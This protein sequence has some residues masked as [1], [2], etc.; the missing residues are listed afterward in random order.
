MAIYS[1]NHDSFGKTT[2]HA[3]AAGENAAY[4]AREKE[5]NLSRDYGR[6]SEAAL[7]AAYNA[8]EEATYAVRSHVIPASPNEAEAWFR[9]QEK[10]ERKNA[11]MS[12]RFIGA[13]PREL[14]PDQCIEAVEKFCREVTQ[15]RVPW[16]FALHLELDKRDEPDWNPHAHI[17]IRD[18][19]IET[20]RRVLF[21]TA[22]P[23]ERA[24]LEKK[25]IHAWTTKDFRAVWGEQM[26]HAL[27]RAGHDVRI[28]HR[29]LKEQGIDREP[30]I[31]IGPKAREMAEKGVEFE[32]KDFQR[33][34][35][36]IPYSLL[37]KGLR[38]DHN[39]RIVE[40]NRQREAKGRQSTDSGNKPGHRRGDS[41]HD[42][43]LRRLQAAQAEPRR[44][45]YKDQRR[46]REALRQA[47]A[48]QLEQHKAWA[49]ELYASAR[50]AAFEQVKEQTSDRWKD[51]RAI[52]D[53]AQRE[54]EAAA[55]TG[56]QKALY[57]TLSTGRVAEAREEKNTAWQALKEQQAK[58]RLELRMAHR[59]ESGAMTRQHVAEQLSIKEQ[60]RAQDL[61]RDTNRI[62]GRMSG[63]QG[64]ANQQK[65]AV[66]TIRLNNNAQPHPQAALSPAEAARA[67]MKTAH[68]E[69][70]R[71]REIRAQLNAQRQSNRLRGATPDRFRAQAA[72][73]MNAL[74]HVI[75]A[76]PQ[77]QL[78]QAAQSG[79]AL[80]SE[81]RANVPEDVREKIG[82]QN[83]QA[84]KRASFTP[85]RGG[86]QPN[87]KGRSGG[88]RGR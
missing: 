84:A 62:A 33:G 76:D 9:A 83:R 32:S 12:D 47:Q 16:H 13:L 59:E 14:T 79:R 18:R 17:V 46:D 70:D 31:H 78:R 85:G 5:T 4:N 28:D 45:M 52:R 71:H 68:A 86:S 53:P 19:D 41:Q 66:Q 57:A 15:D 48:V 27:E 29:T 72:R 24:Q 34:N 58:E 10:G 61:Q 21:T 82:R 67:F 7:N 42:S 20:N 3:G 51:V 55:L 87:G 69:H 65:V 26:N 77:T 25:G 36:T 6:A 60:R 54:K 30:Q 1:F 50:K 38:A 22:G 44:Q 63:H 56:E 88:G 75:E 23:K 64:M 80:S 49:K 43:E 81:E 2:N 11:R 8:R 74:G 35:Q 39:A 73:A 40:A 37:D